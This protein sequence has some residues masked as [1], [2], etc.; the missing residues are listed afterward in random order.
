MIR[1]E[2]SADYVREFAASMSRVYRNTHGQAEIQEHAGAALRRGDAVANVELLQHTHGA[3]GVLCVVA[4]DRAGLLATISAAF[5]LANIDVVDA[6]AHT[7]KTSGG[8]KEAVDL[9]WVRYADPAKRSSRLVDSDVEEVRRVLF[10]LLEG[11][12]DREVASRRA[13]KPL[14]KGSETTVRFVENPDGDLATLEVETDDRS[15]LLLALS[16]AL[17]EQKVQIVESE[18]KTSGARVLDRFKIVEL[19]GRPIQPARR[20]EIQVAV[21]SAVQLGG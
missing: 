20:L 21:L 18:V 19:D 6:A 13:G 14:A 8:R 5:V 4:D 16:Q 9:F 11:K 1:K 15:G 10:E 3:P 7:R 2:P 17:F 12:L